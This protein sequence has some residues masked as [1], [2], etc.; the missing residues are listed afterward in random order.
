MDKVYK[1]DIPRHRKALEQLEKE[2]SSVVSKTDWTTLRI[3][4]LLVH[5][6]MLERLLHSSQFSRETARLNK[7]VVMFHSDFVYLRANIKAL[8]AILAG[9]RQVPR[10][11][12]R[13]KEKG[14]TI[15]PM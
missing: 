10:E 3:E 8:K 6:K 1:G 11:R 14:E 7:G 4:P 5:V 12:S 2:F 13:R 9:Q 15:R